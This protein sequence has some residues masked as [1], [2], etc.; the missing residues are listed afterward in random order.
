VNT[1]LRL[2]VKALQDIAQN[3]WEQMFTLAAVT[4]VTFLGALLLLLVQNVQENVLRNKGQVK[5]EVY[6]QSGVEQEQVRTQWSEL[7]DDP[8][9]ASMKTFKPGQALG[10]L[11]K[12]MGEDIDLS[13]ID[14]RNP[15]PYTAVLQYEVTKLGENRSI[16]DVYGHIR[17]LPGVSKV[18]F[19]PLQVDMAKT[20]ASFS[21][22]VMWPFIIFLLLLVGLILGNT[23]KLAQLNRQKEV[24]I[25]RLIGAAR[26]YIQF[27]LLVGAALQAVVGGGLALILLKITQGSLNN[28]LNRPPLWL[29]V[30]FLQLSE[31][32]CILLALIVTALISSWA[33]IRR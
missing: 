7:G 4:L 12:S 20:W 3:K 13:W 18:S 21:R 31:V 1:V 9:V 2:F 24:E 8:A 28:L 27:P 11:S 6:W 23:F 15:L 32:A 16:Q 5:F 29:E 25:L 30:N 17:D 22:Q 10:V 26:W 19:N 33:A 14:T